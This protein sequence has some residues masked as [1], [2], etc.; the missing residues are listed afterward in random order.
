MNNVDRIFYFTRKWPKMLLRSKELS[1]MYALQQHK[2]ISLRLTNGKSLESENISVM[3][4][5]HI[6]A[7]CMKPN[8]YIVTPKKT[9]SIINFA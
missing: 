8:L 5:L 6:I 7:G 1:P 4:A 2:Y 9:I 3:R